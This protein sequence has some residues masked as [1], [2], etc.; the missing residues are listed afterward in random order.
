[1]GLEAEALTGG[2]RESLRIPLLQCHHPGGLSE[3]VRHGLPW[4]I[5][6]PASAASAEGGLE[7]WIGQLLAAEM[8]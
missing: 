4:R 5:L 3:A 1:M 8:K 7:A 6:W 2:N